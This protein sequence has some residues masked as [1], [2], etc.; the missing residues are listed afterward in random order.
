MSFQ[1]TSFEVA[2]VEVWGLGPP[3]DQEE[4]RQKVNVRN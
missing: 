1:G 4:E 2:H 3:V